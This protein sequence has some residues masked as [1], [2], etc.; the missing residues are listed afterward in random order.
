MEPSRGYGF[1][2]LLAAS[3]VCCGALVLAATGAVSFA[4]L[5]SWLV[6]GGYFWIAAAVL[7]VVGI[8]LWRQSARINGDEA[9][10]G[11]VT[12]PPDDQSE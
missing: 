12:Y 3:I 11:D 1:A 10:K 7:A 4:G 8:Y 6:G 9:G 5:G 2:G